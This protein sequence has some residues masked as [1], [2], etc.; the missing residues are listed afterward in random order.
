MEDLRRA[1]KR[2]IPH[3]VWEYLDSATGSEATQRRNRQMLDRILFRPAV[4]K[5]AIKPDLS[6]RFLGRTY[7]LPLGI[8]P[9]GMSGLVWP[10]AEALLADHAAAAGLPYGLSTVASRTPEEIGP[11]CGDQGWFQLYPPGDPEMRRDMLARVQRAGFHTLV[12]TVD[13]P[14]PSRR[15][16]QLKGGLTQPA[17]L[18]PRLVAQS[19]LCPRWSLGMLRAGLPRLKFIESYTNQRDVLPSNA[20]IGYQLRVAPDWDYLA[21]LRDD[22][23]GPLIVKGILDPA[24]AA[25]MDGLGI[26]A[27]WV[28]NHAGR[29]FDAAPAAIE[30][31]PEIRG[32]TKLPLI[33]DSG[34]EAGLD[35]MRAI[36]LGADFTMMGR[37][38]H[39]ALAAF[40]R[41]GLTH[42]Q[43]MISAEM[44]AS[45]AQIG[46]HR[47]GDLKGAL[48]RAE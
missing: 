41:D 12:I 19:M 5:G 25:R 29:Q 23:Q 26:D 7:P 20:H 48:Y 44:T 33:F 37:G 43:E 32:A 1:A 42:L 45:M 46:A 40:G 35:V 6:T 15:E 39:Y 13:I 18:T 4:L 9:V 3:F 17:R 30:V 14:A 27:V 8:A 36:A 21:A 34:I 16:R 2:R 11:H 31:L 10:R 24:D 47:L 28:S 38:W 22:W